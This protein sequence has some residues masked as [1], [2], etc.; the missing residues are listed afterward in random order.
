[1]M[2]GSV[3]NF[4]CQLK[5]PTL[6]SGCRNCVVY[7]RKSTSSNPVTSIFIIQNQM[8]DSC[9]W[10]FYLYFMYQVIFRAPSLPARLRSSGHAAPD[11]FLYGLT[12]GVASVAAALHAEGAEKHDGCHQKLQCNDHDDLDSMSADPGIFHRCRLLVYRCLLV[13]TL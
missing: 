2:T 1:M 4:Q 9:I 3:E 7:K 13:F 10:F 11:R 6:R 8:H 12:C 5:V